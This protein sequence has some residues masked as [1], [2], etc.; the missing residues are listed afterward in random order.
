M[1]NA[2]LTKCVR[3]AKREAIV[4]KTTSFAL[5]ELRVGSSVEKI[6]IYIFSSAKNVR[7]RF[8]HE[9]RRRRTSD[10]VRI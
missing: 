2:A 4:L 7:T 5:R 1:N 6:Y 10:E 8:G 3:S 9:T